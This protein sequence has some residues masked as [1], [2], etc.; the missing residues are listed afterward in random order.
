VRAAVGALEY[1]PY[2]LSVV[3]MLAGS[4][5]LQNEILD[6]KPII[7]ADLMRTALQD[8]VKF[9]KVGFHPVFSLG[10]LTFH[11]ILPCSLDF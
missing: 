5:R 2:A 9:D 1:C 3:K 8:T 6:Q 7:L 10:L 11:S 4:A